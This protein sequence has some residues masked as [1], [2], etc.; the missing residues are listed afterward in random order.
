MFDSNLFYILIALYFADATAENS[1][2]YVI[3]KQYDPGYDEPGDLDHID[4]LQRCLN[5]KESFQHIRAVPLTAGEI[6]IFSH[7]ILHWG[8][9]GPLPVFSPSL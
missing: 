1:C 7:R 6:M 4:P 8:S 9:I 3:P 2:L 5:S